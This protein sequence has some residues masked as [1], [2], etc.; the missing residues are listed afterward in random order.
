MKRLLVL[1]TALGVLSAVALV[2]SALRALDG[3]LE[4]VG[5]VPLRKMDGMMRRLDPDQPA[6]GDLF[7]LKQPYGLGIVASPSVPPG[8]LV[9]VDDRAFASPETLYGGTVPWER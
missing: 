3:A 6:P 8:K 7:P 1:G 2:R 9:F 5:R 4:G